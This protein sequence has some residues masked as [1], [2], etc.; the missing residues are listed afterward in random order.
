VFEADGTTPLLDADGNPTFEDETVT[1]TTSETINVPEVLG[2]NMKEKYV[3]FNDGTGMFVYALEDTH[4]S[5]ANPC[6]QM[7]TNANNCLFNV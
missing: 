4:N 7:P 6:N 3:S 2:P 5:S 1:T